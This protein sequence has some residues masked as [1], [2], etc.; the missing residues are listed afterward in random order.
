MMRTLAT[1]LACTLLLGLAPRISAAEEGVRPW[2]QGVS[3]AN[4]RKALQL[5]S[6]GNGM[7]KNSI[8]V[9]AAKKYREALTYWDHPAIHYNLVL[10]LLNLDQPVEVHQNLL[11]AM[12]YGAAP[13]DSDKYEQAGRY[14]MLVEK[15][16]ARVEIRCDEAGAKVVLDGKPLFTAPGTYQGYV[17]AGPHS[18]VATKDGFLP[19]EVSKSLPPAQLSSMDMKLFTEDDLTQYHRK[20]ASWIPWVV[21][22][23][24]VAIAGAGGGMHYAAISDFHSFDDSIKQCGAQ[25]CIPTADVAGKRNTGNTLQTVAITSYA[26]G[27]AALVTG[28]VLVYVNRLQPYHVNSDADVQISVAP[29][30]APGTAGLFAAATF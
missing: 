16:L 26:V 13:L 5:F 14:K 21:V 11:S 22:G 6:E 27:G 30:L 24:G 10:A 17:R 9:E 19:D 25:G 8:F 15:E 28:A 7:L 1:A 3:E 2:A 20:F 23:A 29:M 18:I 4:Q 12:K